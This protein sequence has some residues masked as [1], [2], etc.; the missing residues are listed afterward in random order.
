MIPARPLVRSSLPRAVRSARPRSQQ[1]RFQSTPAANAPGGNSH[2]ASGVAGGIAAAAA[3]YG[4]YYVSPAGQMSRK[5]NKTAKEANQKYQEAASKLSQNTPSADQAID[6]IKQF[7]YSY[8]AWIPGG[9]QYVD[10]AFKDFETVRQNHREE[11]DQIVNDA[12]RQ[13]QDVAKS[14]LSMETASKAFDVLADVGKKIGAL[15]GDA[16]GDILENHPDLKDKVGGNVEQLKQMGE[17]YGPEAKKQV[18]ETWQQVKEVMAG[19]LSASSLNK[20]R[21]LIEKGRA[22]QEAR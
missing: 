15:A 14:G 12:Y 20:A 17:Q 6:Y 1:V 18:D 7:A 22:G 11:A 16:I 9:R 4:I 13:F 8:V 21:K 3:L 10:T 19:G 5:I 2:L